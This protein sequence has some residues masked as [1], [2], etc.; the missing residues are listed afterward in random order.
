MDK[1]EEIIFWKPELND[2]LKG[3]LIEKLENVG[4]YN[5]NL[6]K[7]QSGLNVVCVWGRFHLDSIMEAASVG[8]MILLRYVG[9]TKTKNH[10]MKKYELEILNNNHDQ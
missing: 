3:V 2:T 5:S 1:K 9:L 10:Q 6:Y 7:I 8:D 4:R